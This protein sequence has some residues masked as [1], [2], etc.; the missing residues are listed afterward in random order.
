MVRSAAA[1]LQ[2]EDG[3]KEE[4][5]MERTLPL[6]I[7]ILPGQAGEGLIDI[8]EPGGYEGV[9]LRELVLKTLGKVNWNIEEKQV[10]EDI[11][12]QLS[13]GKLLIG[14]K[15]IQGTAQRYA[16]LKR[17]EE[18]EYYYYVSMRAIKPQEGGTPSAELS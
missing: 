13:G 15:E 7:E 12:R 8:Y 4:L 5:L 1:V 3:F 16:L 9:S 11:N 2:Q 17:T 14:G 6:V 18:G 10:L